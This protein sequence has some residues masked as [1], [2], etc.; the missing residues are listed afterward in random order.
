MIYKATTQDIDWMVALSHQ[1]RSAYEK[2][3]PN[4]WKMASDSD[5]IQ[6]DYFLEEMIKD[7][8]IALCYQDRLGF[9]IGK[10]IESPEVYD[11]G[12]TLMIDDFCVSNEHLWTTIGKEL[13]RECIN[14]GK[15]K[16]AT[17]ILVV[18]GNHDTPKQNLL[19]GF[20]LFVV[21]KWFT[22]KI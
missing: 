1:K 13:L 6:Q 17:Q 21:S 18:C 19:D 12:L 4:F 7:E 9:V 10:L 3:Q 20:N 8:V 5:S 11:A 15:I 14:I 16:G 22:K 2:V